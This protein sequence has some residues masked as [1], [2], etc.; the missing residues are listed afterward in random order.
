VYKICKFLIPLSLF[1]LKSSVENS[2][3][4]YR[5]IAAKEEMRFETGRHCAEIQGLREQSNP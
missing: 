5:D 1:L 4:H 2:R 3:P